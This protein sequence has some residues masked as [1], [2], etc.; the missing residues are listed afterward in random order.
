MTRSS[1]SNPTGRPFSWAGSLLLIKTLGVGVMIRRK[2]I[3]ATL[4]VL[5]LAITVTVLA[6]EPQPNDSQTGPRA[7]R[8]RGLRGERRM[9][10]QR[11]HL[12]QE[13][14]LS[15]EQKQQRKAIFQRSMLAT[16]AQR[17]QLFQLREKRLTGALTVEDRNRAQLLRMQLRQAMAEARK[18]SFI[19]L[20]SEQKTRLT[21]L[22]QER[23]QRRDEMRKR[24]LE[25][26]QNRP[27]G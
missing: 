13:L 4:A 3:L 20:T 22:Q 18:E 6:Q 9:K 21:T 8:M 1:A 10:K 27:N 25:L 23:K 19:V 7:G 11:L 16:K 14:Q 24:R 12:R 2:S 26:R 15:E 5:F 17:E